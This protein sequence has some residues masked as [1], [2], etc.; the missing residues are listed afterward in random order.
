MTNHR[1]DSSKT[2]LGEQMGFSAIISRNMG[3]ELPSEAEM[4]QTQLHH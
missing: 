1:S 4:T 2:L 3:E